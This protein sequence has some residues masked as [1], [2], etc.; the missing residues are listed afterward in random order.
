MDDIRFD[1]SLFIILSDFS[2]SSISFFCVMVLPF[3]KFIRYIT[4][5]KS[6][7]AKAVKKL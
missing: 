5:E 1:G 7:S 4:I 2:F 3:L 6:F